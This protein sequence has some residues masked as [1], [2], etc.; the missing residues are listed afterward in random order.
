[1][2]HDGKS[3]CTSLRHLQDLKHRDGLIQTANRIGER[4]SLLDVTDSEMSARLLIDLRLDFASRRSASARSISMTPAAGAAGA[5]TIR[6]GKNRSRCGC[7]VPQ[8]ALPEIERSRRDAGL[9]TEAID[10]QT[11][12]SSSLDQL[13]PENRSLG[14]DLSCHRRNPCLAE[15]VVPASA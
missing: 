4:R 5:G 2:S 7:L 6:T 14:I 13:P 10:A 11:A 1:M 9:F 15:V 3:Y 8:L 12:V